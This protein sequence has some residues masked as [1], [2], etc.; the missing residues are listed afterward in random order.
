MQARIFRTSALIVALALTAFILRSMP[1]QWSSLPYNI[2]GLSE[3][4][5]AEDIIDS[6][7]LTFAPESSHRESYVADM[8]VL[9]LLIS[10]AASTMG[11]SS[12]DATTMTP[13][14]LGAYTVSFA[15][16]LSMRA[17][18]NARGAACAGAVL[19]I[20]GSFAFASGCAWKESLGLLLLAMSIYSYL[21]REEIGF[22]IL[23][24][25]CL[26]MLVFSHHYSALVGLSIISFMAILGSAKALRDQSLTSVLPRELLTVLPAWVVLILYYRQVDLPY[27]DYLSPKADLYLF[28]AVCFL[29]LLLGTV[30]LH[31][32]RSLIGMPIGLV[33]IAIGCLL[34]AYNYSHP[35][36]SGIPAPDSMIALPS[37]AYLIL[38][39]IAWEGVRHIPTSNSTGR[40]TAI[41]LIFA[42][43]SFIVF[44]LLR[45]LDETSHMIVFRTFDF[46]MIGVAMLVGVGFTQLVKGRGRLA[47]MTSVSLVIV[48][49]ATLP[50]AYD[51]QRLFGVQNHTFDFEYD[52]V[53]W[54]ADNGV[55]SYVSDQRLGE[56]GWRLFDIEFGR[57]LPYVMTE[58]LSLND[59]TFYV[60]EEQWSTNGAQEFPFGVVVVPIETIGQT[61]S[62]NSVVYV[63]GPTDNNIIC[64]LTG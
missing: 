7:H 45:S 12:L 4:R 46:L 51:S 47:I 41:A 43:L 6:G 26:F 44:A 24:V 30:L 57:G 39:V 25:V 15:L 62:E 48:L 17:F 58:G 31:K 59:T 35:I 33:V 63:G 18:G 10:F 8:P 61:L 13:A 36:F 49:S 50:V 11:T 34:M 16:I 60:L 3:Y 28:L 40:L 5:V 20:A 29:M 55:E 1:C 32:N 22:R 37:F 54:F 2:D 23:T 42:P 64:F 27:L 38:G 52:A 53:S 56:T 19:A 14:L 21:N 9:G